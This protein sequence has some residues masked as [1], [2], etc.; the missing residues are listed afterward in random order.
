MPQVHVVDLQHR[1]DKAA[2][3]QHGLLGDDQFA[4]VG[5]GLIRQRRRRHHGAA[6]QPMRAVR[7]HLEGS[8]GRPVVPDVK[9]CAAQGI[10]RPG[11]ALAL[12]NRGWV[13][14]KA[15][16]I[17]RQAAR[18]GVERD[19][20]I[21]EPV[22]FIEGIEEHPRRARDGRLAVVHAQ[23]GASS[24]ACDPDALSAGRLIDQSVDEDLPRVVDCYA[25]SRVAEDHRVG[26][27]PGGNLAVAQHGAVI[28]D[29]EVRRRGS[30]RLGQH[31]K[32]PAGRDREVAELGDLDPWIAGDLGRDRSRQSAAQDLDPRRRLGG[33]ER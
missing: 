19:L 18:I 3:C 23:P 27:G 7:R 10:D 31:D 29:H 25:R 4:V 17:Q 21:G 8:I 26:G 30:G 16:P 12:E 28:A 15:I 1:I 13:E 33:S 24:L 32:S 20:T 14:Q 22:Q 6:H 9:Q 5:I 11:D 2:S